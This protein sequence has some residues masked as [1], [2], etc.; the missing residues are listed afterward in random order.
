MFKR[1]EKRRRKQEEEE[2]LGLN[3]EMKEVLG[4]HDTDTDESSSSEDESEDEHLD[5]LDT[6][7]GERED[8]EAEEEEGLGEEPEDD[9]D[10]ESDRDDEPPISIAEAIRNPLYTISLESDVKACIVCPGK[11]LKNTIMCDVHKA[12]HAHCRRFATFSALARN[13]DPE[14]DVRDLVGTE[15][16]PAVT[17]STSGTL[18]KRAE[19]K[20]AKQV[21]IRA[22]REMQKVMKAKA[23]AKK[24][25]KAKSMESADIA[26]P[27]AKFGSTPPKK[28]RK[29]DDA[30]E[31]SV[32]LL[33]PL[34]SLKDGS[35]KKSTV[36]KQR[37]RPTLSGTD[38][39]KRQ[40]RS[41]NVELKPSA[42]ASE[43]KER[44]RK[45]RFS[46][47]AAS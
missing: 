16:V 42:K 37:S 21:A 20:K 35:Q 38:L 12:S 43:A 28:K 41:T 29:V 34:K 32:S 46:K 33:L 6:E 40:D 9:M 1:V 8:K 36:V 25:A 17:K 3:E 19:K 22:K 14:A 2:E 26:S 44:T 11:L 31:G 7:D 47:G 39:A 24:E 13:A 15:S 5:V 10:E 18:S 4:M 27:E 30:N 23:K 45:K